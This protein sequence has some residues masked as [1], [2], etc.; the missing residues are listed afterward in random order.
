MSTG[1]YEIITTGLQVKEEG[2]VPLVAINN[3]RLIGT[4][5]IFKLILDYCLAI[6]AAIVLLPFLLVIAVS[7][8]A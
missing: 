8:K 5:R 6:P 3:V 7:N 4:D 1:L 2:M